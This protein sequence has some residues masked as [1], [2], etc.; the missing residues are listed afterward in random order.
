MATILLVGT[1]VASISI[2]DAS[3]KKSRE[4]VVVGS[5]VKE[6]VRNVNLESCDF[7]LRS[8]DGT[9]VARH[10]DVEANSGGVIKLPDVDDEVLTVDVDCTFEDRTTES[11]EDVELKEKGT[12]VILL[13]FGVKPGPGQ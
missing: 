12:T 3:A 6:V 11:A 5:K 7:V 10:F 13:G 9:V 8:S 2:E 1:I 4:I